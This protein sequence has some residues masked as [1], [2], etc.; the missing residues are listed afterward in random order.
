M[1]LDEIKD[2]RKR[3]LEEAQQCEDSDASGRCD[4]ELLREAEN[5]IGSLHF[6][7]AISAR[8][9]GEEHQRMVAR[10]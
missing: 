1:T 5:M 7:A 3:L 4:P 9:A 2:L 6:H 10:R 8:A